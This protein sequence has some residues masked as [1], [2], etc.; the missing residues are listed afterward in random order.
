[1]MQQARAG[2]QAAGGL[3]V[4]ALLWL[5]FLALCWLIVPMAPAMAAEIGLEAG[6]VTPLYQADDAEVGL[7]LGLR[8]G[9][10]PAWCPVFQGHPLCVDYLT[11]N[12]DAG[13]GLAVGLKPSDEDNGLRWG[14]GWQQDDDTGRAA[15][16]IYLRTGV[17][18]LSW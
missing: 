11:I 8:L 15:W 14:V 1:M 18:L 9:E 4:T 13:I 17:A 3:V 5:L 7:T 10:V 12:R 6:I 2:M 16:C